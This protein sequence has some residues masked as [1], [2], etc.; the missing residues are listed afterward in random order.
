MLLFIATA[1]IPTGIGAISVFN[2]SVE[3]RVTVE[4]SW[5]TGRISIHFEDVESFSSDLREGTLLPI[6]SGIRIKGTV[7]CDYLNKISPTVLF[8]FI[9]EEGWENMHIFF[10]RYAVLEIDFLLGEL[11]H[12][13]NYKNIGLTGYAKGVHITYIYDY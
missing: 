7:S 6:E 9:T 11:T 8:F 10:D 13:E 12:D 1:I 5:D 2:K 4:K 3:G